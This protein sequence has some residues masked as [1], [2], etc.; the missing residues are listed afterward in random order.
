MND[1][2]SK[3]RWTPRAPEWEEHWA[4]MA[5]G[6]MPVPECVR[7]VVRL[8]MAEEVEEMLAEKGFVPG[9]TGE[10]HAAFKAVMEKLRNMPHMEA[11][12]QFDRYF[13]GLTPEDRAVLAQLQTRPSDSRLAEAAR[14]PVD[15]FMEIK[16]SLP[17]KLAA[18]K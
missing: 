15:Q 16:H 3:K 12:R 5:A 13:T 8:V 6:D 17:D 1:Y 14:L 9:A 18:T 2:F 4:A 7:H 10:R 11:V